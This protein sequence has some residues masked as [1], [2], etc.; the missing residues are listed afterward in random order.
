MDIYITSYRRIM[1]KGKRKQFCI[2]NVL[3]LGVVGMFV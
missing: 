2:H 1:L 3:V